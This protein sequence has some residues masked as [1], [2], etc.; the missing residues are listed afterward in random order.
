MK[1]TELKENIIEVRKD[2]FAHV[3]P[4]PCE[5]LK[6]LEICVPW[7]DGYFVNWK[8]NDQHLGIDFASR[9]ATMSYYQ[10]I[11]LA[12]AC[13]KLASNK[14]DFDFR[15]WDL[16]D[17]EDEYNVIVEPEGDIDDCTIHAKVTID[18]IEYSAFYDMCNLFIRDKNNKDVELDL[19]IKSY[20]VSEL[21]DYL[22]V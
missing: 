9:L 4:N 16:R 18:D 7:K 11:E 8:T 3:K 12:R 17:V 6:D 13:A 21:D 19:N 5:I 15:D 22:G 1:Q 14:K 20:I 2:C 10:L